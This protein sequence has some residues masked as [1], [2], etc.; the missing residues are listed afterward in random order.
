MELLTCSVAKGTA[1]DY[2]NDFTKAALFI[3]STLNIMLSNTNNCRNIS[4]VNTR[5]NSGGRNTG[6]GKGKKLTCSYSPAEWRALSQEEWKRVLKARAKAKQ[7]KAKNKQQNDSIGNKNNKRSTADINTDNT[8][9]CSNETE[10]HVHAGNVAEVLWQKNISS[11]A[12]DDAG[13]HI[14]SRCPGNRKASRISMMSSYRYRS[15][16]REIAKIKQSRRNVTRCPAYER[17]ELDSRA[18]TCCLG[19]AY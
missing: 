19:S 3:A 18:D 11:V 6:K 5:H 13:D 17:N 12:T 16:P 14:S 1:P 2:L 8:S 9:E 7:D 4:N 10:L 15:N